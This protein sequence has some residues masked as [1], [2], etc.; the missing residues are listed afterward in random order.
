MLVCLI[1]SQRS[2]R[3]SSFL[4]FLFNLF[5][6]LAILSIILSSISSIFILLSQL[7]CCW[8][9]PG[10]FSFQLLCTPLICSLVFFMPLLSISCI[11]PVHAI[12]PFLRLWIIF[13]IITL[14]FFLSRLHISSSFIWSCRLLFCSFFC[15]IFFCYLN[16]FNGWDC[17]CLAVC[18]AWGVQ[19]WHFQTAG[20]SWDLALRWEPLGELTLIH[21]PRRVNFSVSP[22][23]WTKHPHNRGSGLTSRLRTKA[24]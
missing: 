11:F 24:P 6:S 21:S 20:L 18:L 8:F 9:L 4:F 12:I 1:L 10:Y 19:H 14:N 22:V 13:T 15:N 17:F 3:L 2:L 16:I 23:T 7:F 5:Y